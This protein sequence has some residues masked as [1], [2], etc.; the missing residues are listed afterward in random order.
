MKPS[1][2]KKILLQLSCA[3]LLPLI[4]LNLWMNN[5]SG[6]KSAKVLPLLTALLLS[7]GLYFS[8]TLIR[9]RTPPKNSDGTQKAPSTFIGIIIGQGEALFSF[10]NAWTRLLAMGIAWSIAFQANLWLSILLLASTPLDIFNRKLLYQE[11]ISLSRRTF[12]AFQEIAAAQ[13]Y[14]HFVAAQPP[15]PAPAYSRALHWLGVLAKVAA[16]VLALA[17]YVIQDFNPLLLVSYII[18]L[19]LYFTALRELVSGNLCRQDLINSIKYLKR[20]QGDKLNSCQ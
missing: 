10:L 2:H 17:D 19:P 20:M 6:T 5:S 8:S 4:A 15:E 12:P 16:T 14:Q 11:L 13:Q 1:K 18:I 7:L 9:E 3:T